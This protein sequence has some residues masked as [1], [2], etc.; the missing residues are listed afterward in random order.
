MAPGK[1]I[2]LLEFDRRGKD[3]LASL[4]FVDGTRTI[5]A[6]YPA[7][8]QGAGQD[9]WRADDGGVLSPEGFHI[10]CALQRGDWYALGVAWGGAEGR[11]LSLWISEG[12]ERFT[13]VINDYWYQAP[14]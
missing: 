7:E 1:Q 3:A 4:V 12:R 11:S 2:A 5:F 8:F 6:D 10:V 14:R 13:E 9:L